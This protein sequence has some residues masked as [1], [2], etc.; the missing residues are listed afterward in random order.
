MVRGGLA[1]VLVAGLGGCR[2][3]VTPYV[4]PQVA[5]APIELE[6]P[7]EPEN[8]P[9]IQPEPETAVVIP[10]VAEPKRPARRRTA[11]AKETAPP[12]Q[13][14]AAEPSAAIAIGSLSSGGDTT[15]QSRQQAKDLIASI[16]KRLGALPGRTASQQKELVRQVRS[17]LK[18]AQQA[19]DSGDAEGAK[20]L[21]TKAKL[22]M[23]D[24]EKK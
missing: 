2:H 3:K 8:P 20:T 13:V 4:L 9:M 17:F 18:Q 24:V 16:V 19:L 22:L 7:P 21:A 14:A 11:P 10:P 6:V 15:P 5:Q 1:A 23:D 12:V